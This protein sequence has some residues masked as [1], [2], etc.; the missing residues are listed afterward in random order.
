MKIEEW[1]RS[2]LE[3]PQKILQ[4]EKEG[5]KKA[6]VCVDYIPRSWHTGVVS[7]LSLGSIVVKELGE[8]AFAQAEE[9]RIDLT[10]ITAIFDDPPSALN[11]ALDGMKHIQSLKLPVHVSMAMGWGTGVPVEGVGWVSLN[12]FHAQRLA[13]Q[14]GPNDV[15]ASNAFVE[16][17]GAPVGIGLFRPPCDS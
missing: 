17:L 14:V 2:S 16:F 9:C 11:A 8:G 4:L 10:G 5:G 3:D 15:C 7:L 13:Q 1:I 12:G 6:C